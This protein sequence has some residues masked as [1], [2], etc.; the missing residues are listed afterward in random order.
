M[1]IVHQL[2]HRVSGPY[3]P[4]GTPHQ[5]ERMHSADGQRNHLGVHREDGAVLR[6]ELCGREAHEG[7]NGDAARGYR[8]E[9][10]QQLAP[11]EQVW[12][13]V[14]HGDWVVS[15]EAAWLGEIHKL[16]V[17]AYGVGGA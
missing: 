1:T 3:G 13:K 14:D 15:R 5:H 7:A 17:A 16:G 9:P 8:H 6:V 11:L 2:P 4:I 10:S 12:L